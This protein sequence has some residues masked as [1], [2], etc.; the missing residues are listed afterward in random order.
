MCS[1][2]APSLTHRAA[3][4]VRV[5]AALGHQREDLPLPRGRL[6]QWIV[7][8]S[9]HQEL[10]DDLRVEHRTAAR[11]PVQEFVDVGSSV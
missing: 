10:G 4:D 9:S 6:P 7:T 11:D 2:T 8:T 5:G 1:S 3:R